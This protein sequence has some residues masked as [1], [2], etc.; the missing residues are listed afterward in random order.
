MDEKNQKPNYIRRRKKTVTHEWRSPSQEEY[1]KIVIHGKPYTWNNNGF[2]NIDATPNSGVTSEDADAAYYIATIAAAIT[3]VK[4]R[5]S[6]LA[7]TAAF[8]AAKA[9]KFPTTIGEIDDDG[10]AVTKITKDQLHEFTRIQANL[11]NQMSDFLG[12]LG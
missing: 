1:G 11:G 10:T 12:K 7:L 6:R 3:T 2:W 5:T 4:Q 9:I 8:I